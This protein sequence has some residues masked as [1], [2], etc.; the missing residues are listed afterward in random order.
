MNIFLRQAFTETSGEQGKIIQESFSEI[1]KTFDLLKQKNDIDYNF[2]TATKAETSESFKQSFTKSTGLEFN[3]QNFRN[4]R[5]SQIDKADLLIFI[6]TSLSE[7]SA[8]EMAYNLYS[9]R[10]APMFVAIHESAPIKTTLIRD[11]E[12]E[13]NIFYFPFKDAKELSN[14][15]EMFVKTM[16]MK[17]VLVT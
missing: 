9:G 16:M 8:F 15:L 6:R 2:L 3:P 11:L 10:K 17:K 13:V 5:L 1:L 7:S 4:F 12:N 14:P